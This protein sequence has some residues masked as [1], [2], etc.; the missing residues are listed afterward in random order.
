MEKVIYKERSG[1]NPGISIATLDTARNNGLI[2]YVQYVQN[3]CVYFT[4]ASL[5]E[6]IAKFTHRAKPVE[7]C[8][9]YR[10]VQSAEA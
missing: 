2:S 1:Q 5:Q 8:A 4:D 3:G 9:T 6:Y 7:K 10:K